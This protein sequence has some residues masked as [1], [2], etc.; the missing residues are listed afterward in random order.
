MVHTSPAVHSCVLPKA[1]PQRTMAHCFCMQMCVWTPVAQDPRTD[2]EAAAARLASI[3]LQAGDQALFLGRAHYGC[4]ATVQ[5]V[6][7]PPHL[8]SLIVPCIQHCWV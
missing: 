3:K 2:P 7:G 1:K 8:L 4:V 5:Q 6:Q